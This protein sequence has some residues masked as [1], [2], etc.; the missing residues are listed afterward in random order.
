[1]MSHSSSSGERPVRE[2]LGDD[3][4]RGGGGLADAQR[5]VPGR[6]AHADDQVPAAGGAG[7]LGQVADDGHA[8]V[9]GRL[10]AEGRRRAGQRQVVV[11]GLGD[12]GD[13][14]RAAG[15]LVDL[16]GG[17]GGVVAADGDQGRDA[18]PA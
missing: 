6:P 13:A 17:E 5:Q 2:L 10:E 16:A 11:D 18:E 15:P 4:E 3:R 14:D 7:V 8:E 12:V 9:A 1:M